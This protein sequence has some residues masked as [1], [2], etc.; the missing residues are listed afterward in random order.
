M[1]ITGRSPFS[2]HFHTLS[3]D[4]IEQS[5]LPQTHIRESLS[6]SSIELCKLPKLKR[7]IV[8]HTVIPCILFCNFHDDALYLHLLCTPASCYLLL[9]CIGMASHVGRCK[10]ECK[11]NDEV[12]IFPLPRCY[13]P[14]RSLRPFVAFKVTDQGSS[15]VTFCSHDDDH[16]TLLCSP[17]CG[18]ST[19]VRVNLKLHL[20]KVTSSLLCPFWCHTISQTPSDRVPPVQVRSLNKSGSDGQ[21]NDI[22]KSSF[23]KSV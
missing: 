18:P 16:S 5:Q 14:V 10:C 3:F 1:S 21:L 12:F 9:S 23:S 2:T 7:D 4:A 11:S 19:V 8:R 15:I 17:L 22:S 20:N 13:E 6:N